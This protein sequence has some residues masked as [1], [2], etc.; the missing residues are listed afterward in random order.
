VLL[1]LTWLAVAAYWFAM[2]DI[3][4]AGERI[5]EIS[6]VLGLIGMAGKKAA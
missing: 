6:S 3:Y 1:V 2:R 5:S 4:Y